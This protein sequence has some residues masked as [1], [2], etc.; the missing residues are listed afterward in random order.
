MTSCQESKT[1]GSGKEATVATQARAHAND[2]AAAAAPAFPVAT[3][4][5]RHRLVPYSSDA[6][7]ALSVQVCLCSRR[8]HNLGPHIIQVYMARIRWALWCLGGSSHVMPL[9]LPLSAP[10]TRPARQC[11]QLL[12]NPGGCTRWISHCSSADLR[13][14]PQP[15]DAAQA[16][17]HTRAAPAQVCLHD[18]YDRD[19]GTTIVPDTRWQML[20]AATYSGLCSVLMP[21]LYTVHAVSYWLMPTPLAGAGVF[22]QAFVSFRTGRGTGLNYLCIWY[23]PATTMYRTP[24]YQYCSVHSLCC[25]MPTPRTGRSPLPR[26]RPPRDREGG[27]VD[28]LYR[29]PLQRMRAPGAESPSL[30][31]PA[32]TPLPRLRPRAA[33]RGE[34]R[35]KG[36]KPTASARQ[37]AAKKARPQPKLH[38]WTSMTPLDR[39]VIRPRRTGEHA[40]RQDAMDPATGDDEDS[41]TEDIRVCAT[42]VV[43]IDT[44]ASATGARRDGRAKIRFRP[45]P[46][47]PSKEAQMRGSRPGTSGEGLTATGA[48]AKQKARQRKIRGSLRECLRIGA[49]TNAKSKAMPSKGKTRAPRTKTSTS[50]PSG[51]AQNALIPPASKQAPTHARLDM[52][53]VAVLEPTDWTVVTEQQLPTDVVETS[54]TTADTTPSLRSQ[55]TKEA[56]LRWQREQFVQRAELARMQATMQNESHPNAESC[57]ASVYMGLPASPHVSMC[58]RLPLIQVL[59]WYVYVDAAFRSA[60]ETAHVYW[61][62]AVHTPQMLAFRSRAWCRMLSTRPLP[63]PACCQ[64][65]LKHGVYYLV[66]YRLHLCT[67]ILSRRILIVI[68]LCVG[69]MLVW[70]RVLFGTSLCGLRCKRWTVQGRWLGRSSHQRCDTKL[71]IPIRRSNTKHPH[72]TSSCPGLNPRGDRTRPKRLLWQLLYIL[73]LQSCILPVTGVRVGSEPTALPGAQNGGLDN[74]VTFCAKPSGNPNFS[75]PYLGAVRKRA[76]KRACD[77]AAIRGGTYYRGT[78]HTARALQ[79]LRVQPGMNRREPQRREP[80]RGRS[81]SRVHVLSWNAGGLSLAMFD[82]LILLLNTETYQHV[83]AVIIQETHWKHESTWR[84]SGWNCVHSGCETESHPGI[85]IMIRDKL[86]PHEF[87]RYDVIQPGRILHVRAPF[88]SAKLDRS[89]DLIGIYQYPW[90]TRKPRQQLLEAREGV[91]KKLDNVLRRLPQRNLL[92]VCGDCNVQ[93]PSQDKHVGTG[94]MLRASSTQP[95]TDSSLLLNVLI[96]HDLCAVNTWRG[97]AKQAYTYSMGNVRTLIDYIFVRASDADNHAKG[98]LPMT[99]F[100][101]AD[102]RLDGR[103]RV[104]VASLATQWKVR[105]GPKPKPAYDREATHA[106]YRRDPMLTEVSQTLHGLMQGRQSSAEEISTSLLQACCQVYPVSRAPQQE[107]RMHMVRGP[108]ATMWSTWRELRAV[109]GSTLRAIILTWKLRVRF[110]AQKRIVDRASRTQRKLRVHALLEQAEIDDCKHNARGLYAT[111]RKL[112]PKQ[113]YKPLQ[114]KT[115]KGVCL[116]SRE[117]VAELKKFFGGVFCDAAQVVAGPCEVPFSPK[118]EAMTR[119]LKQLPAHKAVPH[120]CAPSI[121]WKACADA[122]AP[123]LHSAFESMCREPIPEVSHQWKDGWM[124]LAA[125]AGK[126]LCRACDVRPLALQDPGGKA[127]IRTV[128]EA[129]QPYVDAYMKSIPQYAYLQCRDGQMAILRACAH[130]R[131]VRQMVAGQTYTVHHH[132]DGHRRMTLCGGLTLSLDLRMAFDVLPRML[133]ERSLREACVPPGLISLI[134]AWLTDSSYHL[135]HAG[136]S[137][138]LTPTRG[139]RQGCVLSPLIWTCVTGTMVRDLTALGIT[140]DDLDLYADDYLHQEIITSFDAFAPALRKMGVIIMYLQDQGLQVSLEKTVVLGRVAGTRASMAMKQH[141]FKRK[142]KDG[143]ERLYIK[144]PT[145][146]TTLHFPMVQEH[147]Y[148]GIMATY[149]NFEDSTLNHRISSAK[150]TYTRLKPFLRS[151]KRLSLLGRLRMW[152]ACVWSSMRYALPS[153]G[154]TGAGATTLRGLV[155]THMRALAVSPRHL[156]GESTELLFA[157]L[158]VRDPVCMIEALAQQQETR[159]QQCIVQ[160]LGGNVVTQDMLQQAEWSRELWQQHAASDSRSHMRLQRL[161]QAEEG[162]PCPHCGLYFISE[163]A[164]TTHIGHQHAELHQKVKDAVGEM[165]PED[166]GINGM[167]TCRF[168]MKKHHSWQTLKRH[169]QQGRC[170]VLHDRVIDGTPIVA[171]AADDSNPAAPKPLAQ[172]HEL[173]QR[174]TDHQLDG[175]MIANEVR[176]QIIQNCGICGQWI[177]DARQVKQHIRQSHTDIW[178]QHSSDIDA[179]CATFGRSV[180]V[181]CGFCGTAKINSSNRPR[182]AK[183]CGV[184]FQTLLALRL[185]QQAG[186]VR[187]GDGFLPTP[188]PQR[189]GGRQRERVRGRA[190][191]E[192][193]QWRKGSTLVR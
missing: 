175:N 151:R 98:C 48:R 179:L 23:V 140:V 31:Q 20:R 44:P 60:H 174:L 33:R 181:P 79:A 118:L 6:D 1:T 99:T 131:K 186:H 68:R 27:E 76:Y 34:E 91:W 88:G 117:E 42:P 103:H 124:V 136:E 105:A 176:A 154:V 115:D 61:T 40:G 10:T 148:M 38:P 132:R 180:T 73:L 109:R 66:P 24:M 55:E 92:F 5:L 78:W 94:I 157:R 100:P 46:A 75:G 149:Y 171:A 107:D 130:L 59:S 64:L 87:V 193:Q 83:S 63:Y 89:L 144:V 111:V 37:P 17:G 25:G 188:P 137:F 182:H 3:C 165:R 30:T 160:G 129:I 47:P 82:E 104:L 158:G 187:P 125:K 114:V 112:A 57:D 153:V 19:D 139:I 106:D 145:R 168:C 41:S 173:L 51:Q 69:V 81:A 93:L 143:I 184:L 56:L 12:G 7:V 58:F 121:A 77:R 166:M 70:W 74:E 21:W 133:V 49:R 9:P 35:C 147:K 127:A 191:S 170:R 183:M 14:S 54:K 138:T 80:A 18:D 101:I 67:H 15:L 110:K 50:A 65:T 190:K 164:V 155:A 141:T 86:V 156:T 120:T 52:E 146:Q 177:A 172:Q 167:P 72:D 39:V 108:I 96:A 43:P 135:S 119:A 32:R 95:A 36:E 162:W 192:S 161:E 163:L 90:D 97:P 113:R 45:R 102:W 116:S 71:Q 62:I 169:I 22:V 53:A 123:Y 150:N 4:K 8:L 11:C 128:K 134:M 84:A 26:R 29:E 85:L 178:N 28:P 189:G 152:W 16:F 142:D 2:S 185:A 13:R 159:L 126:P 122:L